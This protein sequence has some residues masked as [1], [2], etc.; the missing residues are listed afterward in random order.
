MLVEPF[1]FDELIVRADF[2]NLAVLHNHDAVSVD[3]RRK[4]VGD[5]ESCTSCEQAVER[6]LNVSFALRIQGACGFVEQN[7]GCIL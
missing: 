5:N 4:P 7:N 6:L 3:N 1:L 2:N